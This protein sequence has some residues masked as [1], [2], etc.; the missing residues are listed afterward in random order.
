MKLGGIAVMLNPLSPE[1]VIANVPPPLEI[2]QVGQLMVS[3]ALSLPEPLTLIGEVP[4]A[5]AT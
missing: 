2:R 1:R 5:V 3:A 4:L